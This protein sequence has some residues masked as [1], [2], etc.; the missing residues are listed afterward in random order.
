MRVPPRQ[1]R[2]VA[3]AA[4]LCLA[5]G[6]TLGVAGY[7]SAGPTAA[8]PPR[9]SA[10]PLAIAAPEIVQVGRVVT[11][12]I[13]SESARDGTP[14][15]LIALGSYGPR[16]HRARF[17]HGRA[18]VTLLAADTRQSGLVTLLA[19]AGAARGTATLRLVPG[20]AVEPI[21]PLVGP[22]TITADG[23]DSTLAVVMLADALGNP[24]A[25]G[26]RIRV[27]A[28]HPDG[29]LEQRDVSV[30][31]LLAWARIYSGTRAGATTVAAQAGDAH[32][33]T[34]LL[35]EAAGW[36]VPFTVAARSS[37]LRAGSDQ[38][39]V[40]QT[41]IIRDQFGNV[42][43]D[44]TLVSFAVA[45]P[46]GGVEAIPAATVDGVATALMPAPPVPGTVTVRASVYGV[47]SGTIRVVV[48][49]GLE[50]G[51][52]PVRA[53][54]DRTDAVVRVTA[55]PL[56]DALGAYLP[57]GTPVYARID[58][59]GKTDRMTLVTAAGYATVEM[60]LVTLRP[61]LYSVAVFAGT[62]RGAARVRVP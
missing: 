19:I 45:T 5:L 12:G 17:T 10:G 55:G 42:V 38:D 53:M 62:A 6:A 34:T 60:P 24:V 49:P 23:R 16:L 31:H 36:P 37:G 4:G 11:V 9:G 25:E 46:G 57:D 47:E 30:R 22:R 35:L 8:G 40:L 21:V 29:R 2:C 14:V 33:P 41:G 50:A 13:R 56:L 20:P 18:Q 61:G 26:T 58:G 48:G 3:Q 44:G 7:G 52:I 1:A 51:T 54:I 32:G 27:R 15:V 39:A 28:L 43:P 59:A